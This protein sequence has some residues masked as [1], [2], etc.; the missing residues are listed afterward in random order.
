MIEVKKEDLDAYKRQ[1][2]LD[3]MSSYKV[4]EEEARAFAED[5]MKNNVKEV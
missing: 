3:Y 2:I 5:F 4:N 1:L